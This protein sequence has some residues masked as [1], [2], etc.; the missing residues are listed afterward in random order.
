VLQAKTDP[1]LSNKCIYE[2][3]DYCFCPSQLGYVYNIDPSNSNNVN[4][5][6]PFAG[7]KLALNP[8]DY[9]IEINWDYDNGLPPATWQ[10]VTPD[11]SVVHS[12]PRADSG[13]CN[14]FPYSW[15]NIPIKN[16]TALGCVGN[17]TG[18]MSIAFSKTG[19]DNSGDF[20]CGY[21]AFPPA[22]AC[23]DC[24]TGASTS[25]WCNDRGAAS[26]G[27][28]LTTV[29]VQIPAGWNGAGA[30]AVDMILNLHSWTAAYVRSNETYPHTITDYAFQSNRTGSE[31]IWSLNAFQTNFSFAA[32][33]P[34]GYCGANFGVDCNSIEGV[35][36]GL[37]QNA[38]I[39][40]LTEVVC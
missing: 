24:D 38:T 25:S 20:N 27:K 31:L 2:L 36:T 28:K 15:L 33:A 5:P 16:S 29:R 19:C 13:N 34:I 30:A 9:R 23:T 37:H 6:W 18:N 11:D 1:K 26:F 12:A 10:G 32:P 17:T 22:P 40:E 3:A 14:D 7:F 21:P 4:P 35:Y 8:T 39:S